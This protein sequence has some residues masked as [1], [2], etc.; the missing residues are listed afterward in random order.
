MRF[1]GD[2]VTGA[3]SAGAPFCTFHTTTFGV[4][5]TGIRVSVFTPA[6]AAQPALVLRPNN[7]PVATTSYTP[8]P[9]NPRDSLAAAELI[10]LAWSTAPTVATTTIAIESFVFPISAGSGFAWTY[11]FNRELIVPASSWIVIWN[12]G[13]GAGPTIRAQFAYERE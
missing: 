6:A 5:I 10:D 1:H 12:A 4:K 8:L 11:D 7:T 2:V 9:L 3:P 13:S